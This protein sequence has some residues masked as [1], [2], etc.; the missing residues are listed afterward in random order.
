M[1][2]TI[3]D[4]TQMNTSVF[5]YSAPKAYAKGG[6]VVN[7]YNKHMKESLCI[8]TPL[9]L[10]WGGQEGMDQQ[11]NPTGKFSMSLQFPTSDYSNDDLD[12]FLNSM[13]ELEQSVKKSA[14]TYSKEWFGKKMSQEVIQEFYRPLIK[15]SKDPAKYAPTM[16][17]KIQTARDGSVAVD[18][19]DH[20][21]EKVNITE[22]VVPGIKI[23]GLLEANSVW[24]VGK[25]MYG[26][27]WRLVQAKIHKSDKISG[28]SF[29]EDSDSEKEEEFEEE[30]L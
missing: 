23:Q 20:K 24:F 15:P 9:I 8:S 14:M 29:L 5:S 21:R 28:F 1:S 13:K 11:K 16:K 27:S 25:N 18:A 30:E 12:A 17:F 2:Q 10:T 6:K 22:A 7:L 4:G 26:I 3:I 19:Y